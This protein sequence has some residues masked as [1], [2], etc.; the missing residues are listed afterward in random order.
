MKNMNKQEFI[1]F[2]DFLKNN[3]K[4]KRDRLMKAIRLNYHY[5]TYNHRLL[6]VYD[7]KL[8]GEQYEA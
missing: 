4:T 8:S 7:A 6:N 2:V 1:Q 5:G 3:D